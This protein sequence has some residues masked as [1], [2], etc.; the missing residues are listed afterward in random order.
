MKLNKADMV[1]MANRINTFVDLVQD[2][3]G[4]FARPLP[5][6]LPESFDLK[7]T[8]AALYLLVDCYLRGQGFRMH[9]RSKT[10][11]IAMEAMTAVMEAVDQE[12]EDRPHMY[13]KLE[14]AIGRGRAAVELD[15]V[16]QGYSLW[17]KEPDEASPPEVLSSTRLYL[18][19]WSNPK[20]SICLVSAPDE[21][22]VL[23][24]MD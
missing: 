8:G 18:V 1:F 2:P 5:D 3:Q 16:T 6:G 17:E 22:H 9:P 20:P 4:Y 13:P 14:G 19:R 10:N 15:L 21:A 7:V 23:R 12:V 24:L 11:E